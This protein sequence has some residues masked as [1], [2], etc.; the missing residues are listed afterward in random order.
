M[1]P[2][3]GEGLLQAGISDENVVSLF[4]NLMNQ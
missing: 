1:R 4:A 3:F 2:G